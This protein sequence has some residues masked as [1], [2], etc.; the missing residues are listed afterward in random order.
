MINLTKTKTS[1][2]NTIIG[3]IQKAVNTGDEDSYAKADLMLR[4][5][6]TTWPEARIVALEKRISELG[7]GMDLESFI[8][9]KSHGH[10]NN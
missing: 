3:L 8:S 7:R 2:E 9:N 5:I 4:Q 6:I 10:E 1:E